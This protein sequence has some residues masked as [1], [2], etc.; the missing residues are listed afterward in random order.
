L[1]DAEPLLGRIRETKDPEEMRYLQQA[2][3]IL[4]RSLLRFPNMIRPGMTELQLA[5]ELMEEIYSNGAEHVDE[6]LIQSG[7]M[8]ADPHH[9]PSTRKLR[10]KE[11]IVVDATCQ[12][13]GYYADI[14]R[15]F[16]LGRDENFDS[17][18]LSVLEAQEAALSTSKAGETVGAVDYAARSR[19]EQNQLGEFFIHRTGH[20]LGLEVHELPYIVQDGRELL[21]P[22]M[23]FTVEPSVYFPTKMGVRIEDDVLVTDSGRK[24]LTRSLPKGL[25]WWR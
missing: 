4:C 18:Y 7:R 5:R 1:E 21:E 25:G 17:I 6:V 22:R 14:T 8:A 3:L 19:L 16:I 2:A 12:F 11:S 13:A 24:V 15:T 10:R 9:L 20:G 23:V